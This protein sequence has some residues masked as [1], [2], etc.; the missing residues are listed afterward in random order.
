[1]SIAVASQTIP[2]RTAAR[3][4]LPFSRGGGASITVPNPLNAD[5]KAQS[6]VSR[7]RP[8]AP[9]PLKGG[10]LGRGSR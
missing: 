10:G 1:M 2:S 8:L 3:S 4:D 7:A 5:N 9:L 6:L